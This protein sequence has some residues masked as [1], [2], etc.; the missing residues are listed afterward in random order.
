MDSDEILEKITKI[1]ENKDNNKFS[2][3][4]LKKI[5]EDGK[6][7][8]EKKI[9]PGYKD[10]KP[11]NPKESEESEDNNKKYGDLVIWKEILLI[12][13]EKNRNI[14]FV[15]NDKKEDW[16]E[17]FEGK[18]IGTR[19][20]LIREYYDTTGKIFYSL[21]TNDFIK[22]LSIKYEILDTEELNKENEIIQEEMEL[23]NEIEELVKENEVIK[24]D[25]ELKRAIFAD[26]P[27]LSAI[28]ETLERIK[29]VEKT[30][31]INIPTSVLEALELLKD[32]EKTR[33]LANIPNIY[34]P[35]FDT[36]RVREDQKKS[37][38][39]NIIQENDKKDK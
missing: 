11:K 18:S 10:I 21:N 20:E 34:T 30:R 8:Y 2:E 9:P 19:K 29:D 15:S 7:R 26:M 22:R 14:I 23:K 25:A 27:N 13:K 1:F 36:L 35:L 16:Q 39:E 12:G 31:L 24:E 6:I 5:F 28:L 32:T 33:I 3:E 17:K 4:E 38:L 37:M